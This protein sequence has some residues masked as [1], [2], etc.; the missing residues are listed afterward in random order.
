MGLTIAVA[1]KGGTGKTTVA[2][3][4]IGYLKNNTDGPI[5]AVDADPTAN[6]GEAIGLTP[7]TSIGTTLAEFR[8]NLADL[9]PSIPKHEYLQ[10][11]LAEILIEGKK[12][13]LLV[14]GREEGP[15]CYCYPNQILRQYLDM[16]A[17]NYPYVIIDN[18][19]GME[20]L[21]RRITQDIDALLLVS[22]PTVRGVKTA[23][24]LR[25][26]VKELQLTVKSIYLLVERLRADLN[27]VVR[28]EI[29]QQELELIQTIPEDDAIIDYSL[30]SQS[31]TE[32]RED[33]PAVRSINSLMRRLIVKEA[34][35]CGIMNK[36][37]RI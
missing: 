24:A 23:G 2:A 22:D 30:R 27:P 15:G 28:E 33:S 7:V 14:M 17:K 29:E 5:L 20:H 21:S 34:I 25:D 1:G 9:P 4:I 6:L 16:L 31:L 11:K 3:L 37:E 32:L 8:E 19:A 35:N 26:L 13:D 12:V 36:Y 10:T 18:E